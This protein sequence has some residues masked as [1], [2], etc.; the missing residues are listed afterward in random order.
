LFDVPLRDR[1][2]MGENILVQLAV[3]VVVGLLAGFG[4][5]FLISQPFMAGV[6][7]KYARLF[8]NLELSMSEVLFIALCAGFGEEILFRGALQPLLGIP[9]TSV[10]FVLIH[11]YLNPKDWRISI[12][13]LFMTAVIFGFGYMTEFFG[14]WSA[15]VAHTVIDIIL[16]LDMDGD[17][18]G[19]A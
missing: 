15:M 4:A 8:A 13:G 11:G 10:F 12:Y 17:D 1:L 19:F 9:I 2:L 3:G 6:R 18:V 16:L 7:M 5:R 14:I